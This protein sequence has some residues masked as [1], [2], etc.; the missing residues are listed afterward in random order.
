M[1][2]HITMTLPRYARS[3]SSLAYLDIVEQLCT[4]VECVSSS[5]LLDGAGLEFL[6][7]TES[8]IGCPSGRVEMTKIA[9]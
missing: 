3:S 4:P 8:V 5:T 6:E 7:T 9:K 1:K 2:K